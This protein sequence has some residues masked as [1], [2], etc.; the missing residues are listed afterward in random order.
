MSSFTAL[1]NSNGI[2]QV[3]NFRV[4]LRA[5]FSLSLSRLR[6]SKEII[7]TGTVSASL[8]GHDFQGVG[9]KA[10]ETI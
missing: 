6:L 8:G 3:L 9:P 7:G 2:S 4:T 1:L 5:S 10:F